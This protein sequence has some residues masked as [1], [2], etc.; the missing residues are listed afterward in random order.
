MFHC[1]ICSESRNKSSG[2]PCFGWEV[3]RVLRWF[4]GGILVHVFILT[5][6]FTFIDTMFLFNL[7][8]LYLN[9]IILTQEYASFFAL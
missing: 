6:L 9:N 4:L 8:P 5:L 1:L 2:T 3:N 7:Y